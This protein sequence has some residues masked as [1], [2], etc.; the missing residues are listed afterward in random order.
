[1]NDLPLPAD[2]A[3]DGSDPIAET[4]RWLEQIVIGLNL[5]PFAKAVYV[6]DQVRFV[7]SDATTVEALVEELAEELVLLRDT[8]AEQIDTTLIVH[9][10][11]L[12]DFL[13]Y[14]DFLDNA[15]AAIEALDLQG[16]LQVAS[17]HPQYQFAGVAPDDV[18]NYTNRAPYPTLHLLREDSVERAVAAFPDPDVIVERNIE[19]LDKLGIEGWTRLLGRKDTPRCH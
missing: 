10:D 4:R 6:K 17:F 16:I 1:M 11:V 7:L 15:D 14:N 9:P 5:C 8:P 3:P 13:D 2:T 12:T 19:T 18:S